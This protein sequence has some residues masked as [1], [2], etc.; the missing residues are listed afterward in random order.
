MEGTYWGNLKV[1]VKNKFIF[2]GWLPT[3]DT[4]LAHSRV[5]HFH[6]AQTQDPNA[7]APH[8]LSVD[9]DQNS[10]KQEIKGTRQAV[11]HTCA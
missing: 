5:V 8:F 4:L 7:N 1:M 9:T 6:G 10:L 11:D 3:V 2:K